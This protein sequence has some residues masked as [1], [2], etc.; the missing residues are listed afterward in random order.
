LV[1]GFA[2]PGPAVTQDVAP[3][4][5]TTVFVTDVIPDFGAVGGVAVD[6]LGL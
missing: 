3:D 1:L 4:T 5:V 2:L 6:A